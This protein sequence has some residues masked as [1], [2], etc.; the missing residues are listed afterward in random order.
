MKEINNMPKLKAA[1]D[2]FIFKDKVETK[3]A[4]GDFSKDFF[5]CLEKINSKKEDKSIDKDDSTKNKKINRDI[6]EEL[7]EINILLESIILSL[8]KIE[9]IADKEE[10][11]KLDKDLFIAVKEEFQIQDDYYNS[12]DLNTE[13]IIENLLDNISNIEDVIYEIEEDIENKLSNKEENYLFNTRNIKENIGV[14]K[15]EI[16]PQ[17]E[18][19]INIIKDIAFFE[20]INDE[21]NKESS[22]TDLIFLEEKDILENTSMSLYKALEAIEDVTDELLEELLTEGS[23]ELDEKDNP[24]DFE[25]VLE[26]D[27]SFYE[28]Q[29]QSTLLS[30][31]SDLVFNSK[32]E[33]IE[34]KVIKNPKENVI[35]QV[36]DKAKFMLEDKKSE[37]QIK[38]KPEILG[39]LLLKV[40]VEKGVVVA[41]AIVDNYRVKELIETNI[42]QL[43]EGL[44]EQGLDIKTFEVQVGNNSDFEKEERNDAFYKNK[45]KKL[46]LKKERI[47][48]LDNYEENTIFNDPI[49]LNEFRLDLKA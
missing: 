47:S 38:L 20:K 10:F 15:K 3:D 4:E 35:K 9:T 7:N 33:S 34:N 24:I 17:L 42:I 49:L 30:T 45:N 14:I 31:K 48:S 41:K 12:N 13:E 8:N 23:L 36:I 25:K 28:V 1:N 37:M 11:K 5:N 6:D 27:F 43:K 16:L 26:Q 39:E 18:D 32:A 44:E 29:E 46:K 21:E 2:L 19:R 22:K 40:E